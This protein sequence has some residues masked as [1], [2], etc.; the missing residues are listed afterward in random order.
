MSSALPS[1]PFHSSR[2]FRPFRPSRPFR[3]VSETGPSKHVGVSQAIHLSSEQPY[4]HRA[5]FEA[6]PR[7]DDP[8]RGDEAADGRHPHQRREPRS[9]Q[10][11]GGY[12]PEA[13]PR[14][15]GEQRYCEQPVSVALSVFA[16]I[17]HG[18]VHCYRL[19]N[20]RQTIRGKWTTSGDRPIRPVGSDGRLSR[21]S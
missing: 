17:G 5:R 8:S 3:S 2:S 18:F 9:G 14:S 16:A 4:R 21:R 19:I 15:A 20:M 6:R 10:Q 11:R 7:E 13:D 1:F 12:A